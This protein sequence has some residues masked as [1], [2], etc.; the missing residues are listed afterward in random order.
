MNPQY[1]SQF[2]VNFNDTSTDAVIQ[3]ILVCFNVLVMDIKIGHSPLLSVFCAE[4]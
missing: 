1:L 3:L 4:G 2:Q